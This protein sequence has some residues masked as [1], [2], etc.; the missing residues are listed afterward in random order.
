MPMTV[1]ADH[2]KAFEAAITPL[3]TQ[4]LREKYRVGDFP[5][6]DYV[7][8]LDQRYRWDLFWAAQHNPTVRNIM[9][10]TSYKNMHID[11]VLKRIIP[12]LEHDAEEAS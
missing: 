11:T 5:R 12:P 9:S 2:A 1:T 6:S 3:D 4:E 10:R 8:D 7:K